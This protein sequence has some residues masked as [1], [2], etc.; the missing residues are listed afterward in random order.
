MFISTI[1]GAVAST[2]LTAPASAML[3]HRSAPSMGSTTEPIRHMLFGSLCAVRA[4]ISHLHK[5]HYAEAEDW[6]Q[7]ISTGRPNEVMT[8]LTKK[9][10][11]R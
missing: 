10:R 5:L 1:E 6:S 3:S 9:V 2:V 11:V 7:P 4:T 8:I